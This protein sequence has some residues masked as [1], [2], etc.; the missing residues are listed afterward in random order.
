MK[1]VGRETPSVLMMRQMWSIREPGRVAERMP[2]G[3]AT[4]TAKNRPAKVSSSE[5]GRRVKIS[6]VT[7]RPVAQDVPQSPRHMSETYRMN[8]SMRGLSRPRF[9][10]ICSM[11]SRLAEG[12]ARYVAGS[13]GSARASRKVMMS[14]PAR[15]G[16]AARIRRRM[17]RSIEDPVFRSLRGSGNRA[18]P[19]GP[20]P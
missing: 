8:C 12:P 3:R 4:A 13:P 2:M 16:M 20:E 7:G 9:C 15:L 10:R 6:S 14:T 19:E 1:K 11:A 17:K 18:G 5:A